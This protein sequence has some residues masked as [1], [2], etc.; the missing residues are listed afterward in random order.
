MIKYRQVKSMLGERIAQLRKEKKVSQE[1]LADILCTSRQA[2]SK[3]ERGE[4]DPD[5][6]RLKD[7][8]MYF[9]VSIDY[10]LGY[11]I[12]STSVNRFVKRVKNCFKNKKYD[13]SLDEIKMVVTKNKNNFY[14]LIAVIEY[15]SDYYAINRDKEVV[16]MVIDYCQKAIAIYQPNENVDIT[17]NDLHKTI[18]NAYMFKHDYELIKSYIK[19]N[20]V[21]DAEYLYAQAEFELGNYEEASAAVSNTFL[22]SIATAINCNITQIRLYYRT[23]KAKE[24]LELADWSINFLKSIDKNDLFL[25][26]IYL[27][28]F[29]KASFEGY[30]KIDNAEAISFI[31]EKTH[32]VVG[33]RI[34]NE[35]IKF[36]ENKRIAFVSGSGNIKKDIYEEIVENKANKEL[37][38]P[39]MIIYQEV[40][41]GD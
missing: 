20:D 22:S 38:E 27:T 13:I 25:E 14:I 18:L 17:L 34:E 1:E 16:D 31:K 9:D 29:F 11:D 33:Y 2:I 3:W 6:G 19:Q 4:S 15:L 37:Y 39:S 24:G 5:I 36:Y 7:L 32:Q 28:M 40:F 10:L 41:K 26:L 8:A 30:L 35:G 23:N 12:E 21:H